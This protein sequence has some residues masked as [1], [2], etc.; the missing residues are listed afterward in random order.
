MQDDTGGFVSYIPLRFH[1]DNTVLKSLK[2]VGT[3]EVL[4]EIA[5]GRL[6]LDNFRHIKAYWIMTGLEAGRLA[7]NGGADDFDGTVVEEKITHMAGAETPEGMTASKIEEII[8]AEGK[9]PLR[10]K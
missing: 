5:V 1:P 8:R 9:E 10:R 6:L 3:P 7:L 2:L 4:R